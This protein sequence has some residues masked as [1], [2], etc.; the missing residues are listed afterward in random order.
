LELTR[1]KEGYCLQFSCITRM[2]AGLRIDAT[3]GE[4]NVITDLEA[5]IGIQRVP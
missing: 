3:A 1:S 2:P 4:W 5:A